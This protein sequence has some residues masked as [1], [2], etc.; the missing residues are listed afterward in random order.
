M[1][2]R[3]KYLFFSFCFVFCL[4]QTGFSQETFIS[5]K[6][7]GSPGKLVRLI[8]FDDQF[9]HLPKTLDSTFTDASGS[10]KLKTDFPETTVARLALGLKKGDFYLNPG[11][12]YS[13][14]I[15]L[16]TLTQ[17]G[18]VFD[19]LPLQFTFDAKD[20][21]LIENIGNFNFDYNEFVL[22]NKNRIYRNRDKKLITDFSSALLLKY[23]G[24]KNNYLKN[25]I[26]YTIAQLEWI[27]KAKS[28][29]SIMREYFIDQ[30]VLYHNIQYAE[31]FS[32]FFK[33]RF[34]ATKVYSYDE[35]ISVV[36]GDKGYIDVDRL[37]QRSELLAADTEIRELV[38]ILLLAKKYYNPD[39]REEKVIEKLQELQRNSKYE[40]IRKLAGN[41][42]LKLIHLSY[43]SPAPQFSL[44]NSEGEEVNLAQF[45]G[46]F[47]LLSF[48]REDC[49][50]CH[51]YLQNLEALKKE[52]NDRL[53]IIAIVTKDGFRETSDYAEARAFDWPVLNLGS[54][55]LLIEAY[56]IRAFPTYLL[57]NPDLTVAMATAP[58]P[59]EALDLYIKRS[60]NRFA[61]RKTENGNN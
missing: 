4:I 50:P 22:N 2:F 47:I 5:G 58:M 9:S 40:N 52:F 19:E 35:F 30:P 24:V 1:D 6:A 59:G 57:I 46:K 20:D 21:G 42:I 29:D 53:E 32:D 14:T 25:Y 60:M 39:I 10:F 12:A 27:S 15:P 43:G 3:R 31:F 44:L 54:N 7:E 38:A 41:Y 23:E 56:S 45:E 49:K 61:K 17:R 28:E 36:N 34:G 37:L 13:F 48:N 8:V 51:Y 26:R 55:I 11:S 33:A 18:S 16:D